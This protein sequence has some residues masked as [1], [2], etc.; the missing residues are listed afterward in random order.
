[1]DKTAQIADATIDA[2]D[3]IEWMRRHTKRKNRKPIE[4]F[5]RKRAKMN[6]MSVA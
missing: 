6:K 2:Q 4:H 3:A 1:M 5:D